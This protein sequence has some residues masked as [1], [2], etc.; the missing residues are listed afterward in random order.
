M[1]REIY[2]QRLC[3]RLV[4]S[5]T[6][7]MVIAIE[8]DPYVSCLYWSVYSMTLNKVMKYRDTDA[9]AA[10]VRVCILYIC[11][12]VCVRISVCECTSV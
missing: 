7:V 1:L 3:F 8:N 6:K 11:M 12:Y 5:E 10:F 9:A 4:L 2:E